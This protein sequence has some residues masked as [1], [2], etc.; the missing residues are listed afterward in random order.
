VECSKRTGNM[1]RTYIP[2]TLSH[3]TVHW[4][5]SALNSQV[6]DDR[7]S[8]TSLAPVVIQLHI[9]QWI[10]FTFVYVMWGSVHL[11]HFRGYWCGWA[12]CHHTGLI[13][14]RPQ[15]QFINRKIMI[16]TTKPFFQVHA[17]SNIFMSALR[18]IL[19]D[20]SF[21]AHIPIQNC[22]PIVSNYIHC[23]PIFSWFQSPHCGPRMKKIERQ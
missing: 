10:S 14:D 1:G 20:H 6:I 8:I 18:T 15:T 7:P 13:S 16:E 23:K 22:D 21:P 4:T 9:V 5:P 12:R 2:R 19:G 3:R 17:L 11:K